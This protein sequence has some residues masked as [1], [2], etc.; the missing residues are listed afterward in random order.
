[1]TAAAGRRP[2][3]PV[4]IVGLGVSGR[5]V[6]RH[7]LALGVTPVAFDSRAP[8][9][10]GALAPDLEPL[11]REGL[12]IRLGEAALAGLGA[13]ATA[14]VTPG[15][16]KDHPALVAARAGGTELTGEIPYVLASAAAP[17][18][19]IT[20]SAGKTTT[21]TLVGRI[22]ERAGVGA[23]VGGNIGRPAIEAL[24]L[25]P[26]PPWLVL[27]LSS[28]QLDLCHLSPRVGALLNLAPNHLDVH[29]TMDEYRRAKLNVLAH[30]GSGDVAVTAADHPVAG[31]DGAGRARARPRF[32]VGAAF[33]G[34]AVCEGTTVVDGFVVWRDGAR[35]RRVLPVDAVALPGRHNLEN[36]LAAVLL[37]MLAGAPPE[38]AG[39]AVRA[40]TG[41]AHRL[42]LVHEEG[43]VRY[44]DDSIATAPDRT[45]AALEAV[46][47]G[48]VL[49]AGGSDKGVGYDV[50]GPHLRA[51]VRVL[52][53][54]GPTGPAIAAASHAAGGPA[55]RACA[56]L[57]EAV[58]LARALARPGETVLLAPA[59]ASFD[60]FAN[61][62]ARGDAFARL[63]RG[64]G[65]AF[66]RG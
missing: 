54:M 19:G 59:S 32:G 63:A 48:I 33:G 58:R 62:A 61:Y 34:Q 46:S 1:V 51:R 39:E 11:A 17:V 14:F 4:A 26:A 15:M 30:Q 12:E 8:L 55:A 52:L 45:I 25:D 50:L 16:R 38:A 43:G 40:F 28:F 35:E 47:G 56:D 20:G 27:E 6:A 42:Q 5:A 10:D 29:P 64:E 23:F 7:L 24:A 65:A 57:A 66:T 18:V 22:L 2:L 21:T 13:F 36:V 37:A 49:I 31:A 9:P 41:V 44:V 60:Q 3:A 53:T